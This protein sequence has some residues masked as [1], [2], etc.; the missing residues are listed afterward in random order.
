VLEIHTKSGL[1]ADCQAP[2]GALA[3]Q[4]SSHELLARINDAIGF[5]ATIEI[6]GAN[7]GFD[8]SFLIEEMPSVAARLNHRGEGKEPFSH[9][10]YDVSAIKRYC[11]SLGMPELPKSGAHR[12][13]ADVLESIEHARQCESWLR[14]HYGS[15]PFLQYPPEK[16]RLDELGLEAMRAAWLENRPWGHGFQLGAL[17]EIEALRAQVARQKDELDRR[18]K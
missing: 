18:I 5:D 11:G 2:G 10:V 17:R 15:P 9:Y 12:A 8:A 6:A 3:A 1:R 7:A 13:A 4:N 14:A 16:D